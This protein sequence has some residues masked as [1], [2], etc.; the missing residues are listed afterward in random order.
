MLKFKSKYLMCEKYL[1]LLEAQYL[2]SFLIF[3]RLK[4]KLHHHLQL[5]KKMVICTVT[6]TTVAWNKILHSRM[7]CAH[8]PFES[9]K[10][11]R[12]VRKPV[13]IRYSHFTLPECW[14]FRLSFCLWDLLFAWW[15]K[16]LS[17]YRKTMTAQIWW[18]NYV[19][20]FDAEQ[21]LI[22]NIFPFVSPQRYTVS[23]D[24]RIKPGIHFT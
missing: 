17:G 16:C 15:C 18:L 8:W 5:V 13:Q 10:A 23:K 21:H 11:V 3:Q 12:K 7:I 2:S 1:L 22:T 4:L 24:D 20:L 9:E 6:L 19:V 14:F